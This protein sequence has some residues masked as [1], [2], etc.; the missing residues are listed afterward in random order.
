[1]FVWV[2]E[3]Q[4]DEKA[5]R[6]SIHSKQKFQINNF[7]TEKKNFFPTLVDSVNSSMSHRVF[8]N[9]L[10]LVFKVIVRASQYDI[11]VRFHSLSHNLKSWGY[12][13]SA[14]YC[15]IFVFSGNVFHH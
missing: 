15:R 2:C 8:S 1:M 12:S 11:S 6:I 9:N 13:P 4:T 5:G 3:R 10:V 14:L 7:T